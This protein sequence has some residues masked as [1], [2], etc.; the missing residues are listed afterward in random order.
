MPKKGSKSSIPTESA[1]ITPPASLNDG[2]LPKLVVFD[3]DYTLW[4]FWVDTHVTPPLKASTDHDSA[5]DRFGQDFAFYRE[6]PSILYSLRDR[7][8]KVAA[9][10]RTSAPDLGREML[11]LLHIPDP[12]GKKKKAIEYFDHLEIYPGNKITHFNKLQKATGI[13]FEEMLFFDDE[14]RN[15][16]VETLGVTMYLVRN[17]VSKAEVNNGIKE[18]RKR[19]GHVIETD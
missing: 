19:H 17:G 6:V 16:N 10:S 12:D 18:W 11:R 13:R 3:L 15:R 2:P 9:A 7:G 8:I 1:D 4:P 5:K 14:T